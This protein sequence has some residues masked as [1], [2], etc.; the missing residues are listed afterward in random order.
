ML[1]FTTGDLY[2][3]FRSVFKGNT[4]FR[5]IINEFYCSRKK[6]KNN[7]DYSKDIVNSLKKNYNVNATDLIHMHSKANGKGELVLHRF[8]HWKMFLK[9]YLYIPGIKFTVIIC[10]FLF[11]KYLCYTNI[12]RIEYNLV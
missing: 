3:N 8:I 12:S 7:D 9:S 6:Q 5:N 10:A 1:L 11:L 4:P 2:F